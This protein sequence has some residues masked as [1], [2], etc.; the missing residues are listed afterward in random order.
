[1]AK[2]IIIKL[3][4]RVVYQWARDSLSRLALGQRLRPAE[5]AM[6]LHLRRTHSARG[7]DSVV[8]TADGTSRP[9]DLATGDVILQRRARK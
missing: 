9:Y 4:R 7:W 2:A 6:L 1:M 3:S 5:W 8:Y